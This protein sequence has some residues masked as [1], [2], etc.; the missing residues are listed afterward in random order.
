MA[1]PARVSLERL[2]TSKDGFDLDEA[3]PLQRAIC[4]AADGLPM[5]DALGDEACERHFGC[6]A[7]EL[8]KERP[9]LVAVVAGVRSGKSVIAGAA[10]IRSCLEVDLSRRKRHELA[11]FAIV[12]PTVDN[13]TATFR[14]LAGSIHDAPSLSKMIDGETGD[15]LTL[16]RP[17]GRLVEIVVVAALRGAVTLRSRWLVGFALDEAALFGA[18]T[19]GAVVTAEELLRVGETRLLPG[20]QGWIISSPFG[21]SGLLYDLWRSHFGRPGRV[22]VVH[23]PTRAMNPS[24]PA[25]QI[26]RVRDRAPDVAA[27]EFDGLWIDPDT[28]LLDGP[29][30]D[31][32]TRRAPLEEPPKIGARYAAAWDAATRGNS[33]TLVVARSAGDRVVVSCARQWTGSKVRPL[34]PA[35]VIAEI[36]AVLATYRVRY[37]ACDA[38]GADALQSLARAHGIQLLVRTSSPAESFARYD[39]LRTLVATSAIELAPHPTL[40]QDLKSIRKKAQANGVRI[41]LPRTID[42]RHADFAPSVALAIDGSFASGGFGGPAARPST[43]RSPFSSW[44][45]VGAPPER[46][47]WNPPRG[48]GEPPRIDRPTSVV[49]PGAPGQQPRVVSIPAPPSMPRA[50]GAGRIVGPSGG[51][52][53]GWSGW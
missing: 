46:E 38:W 28:A 30:V 29:S 3:S 20:G 16:R 26:E 17:D 14:L 33:W 18:E 53:G 49:V 22:L 31:A 10:A 34:D 19:T 36:A 24:F 44:D 6:P 12:A 11:R 27:R 23:A 41:E 43:V 2:L 32:C 52:R 37:V 7:E 45:F 35:A 47:S 39:R 8:G 13:A 15:T 51:R 48:D 9:A 21:P 50:P 5:G 25:E 40:V 1:R 42:G 4:R